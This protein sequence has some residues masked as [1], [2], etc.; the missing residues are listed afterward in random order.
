[1]KRRTPE[2]NREKSRIARAYCRAHGLCYKCRDPL[3]CESVQHCRRCLVAMRQYRRTYGGH[4]AT[5]KDDAIATAKT[6][7]RPGAGD[8]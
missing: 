2:E 1:M 5:I 4:R 3:D 7:E 8:Q 6:G